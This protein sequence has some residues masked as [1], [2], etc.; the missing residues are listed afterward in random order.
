MQSPSIIV[1]Y[2]SFPYLLFLGYLAFPLSD[3]YWICITSDEGSKVYI[4][5]SLVIDNDGIHDA[6]QECAMYDTV[7]GVKQVQIEYFERDGDAVLF[8][9]FVPLSRPSW[10]RLMRVIDA[11]E[12]VPKVSSKNIISISFSVAK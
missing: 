12:F 3:R 5:G 10:F 8:L 4:D 6:T 7:V 11:S 1:S 9:E 2:L